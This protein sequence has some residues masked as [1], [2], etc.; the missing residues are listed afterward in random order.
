VTFFLSRRFGFPILARTAAR[1]DPGAADP[2]AFPW[3]VSF[4]D[5]CPDPLPDADP[6]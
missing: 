3:P 6:F 1:S 5:S 2:L 4:P